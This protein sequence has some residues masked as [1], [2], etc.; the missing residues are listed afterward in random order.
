VN[1]KQT[2]SL[3]LFRYCALPARFIGRASCALWTALAASGVTLEAALA[4][5]V[6]SRATSGPGAEIAYALP[7]ADG[8]NIDQ[9][10]EVIL[11]RSAN[12]IYAFAL[13][14]PHENTA[15]RWRPKDHRFQCPR[16][17][18][19]YQPDGTFISGRATRNMDRFALRVDGKVFV[20]LD[21]LFRS[22][23]QKSNGKPP[24]S[25]FNSQPTAGYSDLPMIT[26]PR[27][28]KSS[29]PAQ[30][31]RIRASQRTE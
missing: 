20:D 23:Q 16:H 31:S 12:H 4:H 29:F 28:V 18:S 21:R 27:N 7:S 5:P 30:K 15:L 10:N 9:D 24:W 26:R 13:A 8:V 17:E 3:H 25:R 6:A 22:N 19:K 14:C 2:R 1:E 11:V